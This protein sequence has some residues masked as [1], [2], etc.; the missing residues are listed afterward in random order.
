[1]RLFF[2]YDVSPP[3]PFQILHKQRQHLHEF[4]RPS[5][6]GGRNR[7]CSALV[8]NLPVETTNSEKEIN[9]P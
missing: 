1:M 7:G 3:E 9:D 5:C 4:S 2:L 8:P 6:F